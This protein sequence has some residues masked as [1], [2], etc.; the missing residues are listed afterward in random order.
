MVIKLVVEINFINVQSSSSF[1]SSSI[2]LYK[3]FDFLNENYRKQPRVPCHRKLQLYRSV[4]TL[5]MT[6]SLPSAKAYSTVFLCS[7]V[8]DMI[9]KKETPPENL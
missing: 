5:A 7:L 8:L 2:A 1:I 4:D 9:A 6:V 3:G